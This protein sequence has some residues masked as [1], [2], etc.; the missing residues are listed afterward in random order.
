[1]QPMPVA[2]RGGSSVM[3][4]GGSGGTLVML[5]PGLS[6]MPKSVAC[7]PNDT[8]SSAAI[9]PV[10]IDPCCT[11]DDSCGLDTG[12][13]A[14]VG[15]VFAD[16]CQAKAQPGVRDASCPDSAPTSV[17]FPAGGSTIMVPLNGNLGCC[18][19][20]GKCGVL[21]NELSSPLLGVVSK[22]GLGCV[23]SAPFFKGRPAA[24]CGAGGESFGGAPGTAGAGAAGDATAG[25]SA[26]GAG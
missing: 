10:F 7:A 23:D 20:D 9:G 26:G 13:L 22:L 3:V 4:E 15:A 18:R 8:C 21:A 24:S 19:D 12:A 16:A 11:E 6:D 1:M 2:G 14:L 5:P 17:P 25:V